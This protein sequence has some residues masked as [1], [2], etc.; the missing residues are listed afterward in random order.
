L[1]GAASCAPVSNKASNNV[2]I[3]TIAITG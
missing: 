3:A 1:V 2:F